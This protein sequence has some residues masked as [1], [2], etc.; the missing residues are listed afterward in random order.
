MTFKK[1]TFISK[2]KIFISGNIYSD[3][4]LNKL[5]KTITIYTQMLNNWIYLKNKTKHIVK[6]ILLEDKQIIL[7]SNLI[8]YFWPTSKFEA[9]FH[10]KRI[11]SF[12]SEKNHIF[13]I[14]EKRSG[15]QT[16]KKLLKTWIHLEKIDSAKHCHL[17]SGKI[18]VKPKFKFENFIYQQT[19]KEIC[20]K[21]IPG[22]FSYNKI[23]IG[24]QLLI[25]TF[26][27]SIQGNILDIGCGSGILS[28]SLAKQSS[29]VKLTLVDTH[30][31][32]LVSS[33]LT[34][35]CNDIIGDIFPSDVYSNI[36]KKFNFIMS[37]PSFHCNSKINLSFI[38]TIIKDSVR[39]L[40]KQGEIRIVVNSSISC[41]QFFKYAFVKY[42]ILKENTKFKVYQAYQKNKK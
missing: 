24:S 15:I 3:L 8:L 2:K 7:N 30:I 12:L 5:E 34:L 21:T 37:N 32:A 33:Q 27:K 22:V 41:D 13:L 9:I 26:S 31:A 1:H 17:F 11:L 19:W 35:E 36:H 20:I 29:K 39:Y 14:G 42:N 16:A 28:V 25:S 38:S 40:K 23:D 10:L 18:I 6:F 4:Y